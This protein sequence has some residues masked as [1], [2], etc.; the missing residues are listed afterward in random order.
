MEACETETVT[1]QYKL[2]VTL[3]GVSGVQS[4]GPFCT[5]AS[6]EAVVASLATRGDVQ[7]VTIEKEII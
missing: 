7:L 6:A 1:V 5:R 4:W 3:T 2:A